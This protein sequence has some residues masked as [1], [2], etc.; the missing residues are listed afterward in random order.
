MN[1]LRRWVFH[2]LAAVSLLLC[3]GV[4]EL[5]IRSYSVEESFL[6][7]RYFPPDMSVATT[8]F[9]PRADQRFSDIS[10]LEGELLV[11]RTLRPVGYPGTNSDWTH[12]RTNL[13]SPMLNV[14]PSFRNGFGFEFASDRPADYP[15]ASAW[16]LL[17]PLWL[18][19]LVLAIAPVRSAL[20][21]LRGKVN[22]GYCAKCGYD[23]RA[24]PDRC[25]ECGTI[26]SK[27]A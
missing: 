27:S 22:T 18:V 19:T 20:L 26:A 3:I 9:Q 12:L 4:V 21:L 13:T 11:S 10:I 16:Q 24:T 15:G 1:R 25:P 17:L 23:L 14:R 8:Q 6:Q 7:F 2:I 5:W